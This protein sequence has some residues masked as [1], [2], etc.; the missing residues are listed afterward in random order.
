MDDSDLSS[1]MLYT[2]YVGG[3]LV[4]LTTFF[5]TIMKGLGAAARV[6]ELLDAQPVSIDPYIHIS[7]FQSNN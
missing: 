6:F 1:L 4:G 7:S 2:A 5:S 3:S